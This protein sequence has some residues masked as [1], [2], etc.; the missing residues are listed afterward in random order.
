MMNQE[1]PLHRPDERGGVKS[2]SQHN[3]KKAGKI[4]YLFSQGVSQSTMSRHYGLHHDTIK[5]T[6]KEFYSHTARWRKLGAK[7]NSRLFLK[8]CSIEEEMVSDLQKRL[9]SG[10]LKPTF[11]DLLP[12]SVALDNTSRQAMRA[13]ED[14]EQVN[15]ERP[16]ITQQNYEDTLAAA[17]KRMAEL[18]AV[19]S[20]PTASDWP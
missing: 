19:A 13:R 16:M 4:L 20:R 9:S 6:I 1:I 5:N 14:V 17:R 8:L 11:S 2:L 18:K 7:I 3:P 12:V 15:P 10:E